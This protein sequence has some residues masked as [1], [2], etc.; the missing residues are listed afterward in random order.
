MQKNMKKSKITNKVIFIFRIISIIVIIVCLYEIF[1]WYT[2]NK[3]NNQFLDEI[4]NQYIETSEKVEV[5]QNFIE[6]NKINFDNL[7]NKNSDTVRVVDC[8]K[9]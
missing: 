6:I 3:K 4:S 1:R 5:D 2:E 7:L 8:K 9:Y